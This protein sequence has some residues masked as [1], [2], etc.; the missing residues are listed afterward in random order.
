MIVITAICDMPRQEF[1]LCERVYIHNTYM[2]SRKSCSE[3]RHKFRVKFPGG[4]V[5]NPSTFRRQTKIF[6]ETGSVKNRKVN[7]RRHVLT[8]QT[9]DKI[10][11]RLE[12]T[13]QKSLQRLSQE[14]DVCTKS[15]KIIEITYIQYVL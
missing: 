2:K 6:K 10:G 13:P 3:T 11:K 15:N 5:P 9:L 8:E 4:P 12:H 1:S 7:C 14:T